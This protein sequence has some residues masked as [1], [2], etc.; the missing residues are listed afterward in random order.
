[1]MLDD[2]RVIKFRPPYILLNSA[3]MPAPGVYHLIEMT[4]DE[5]VRTIQRASY[6]QSIKS[7]IGYPDTAKHVEEITGLPV[8]VNR[9][10][11]TL[12]DSATLFIV[13]LRYRV[14]DPAQKGQFTPDSA[15]YAYFIAKYTRE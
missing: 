14:N 10:E 5:W 1:L 7:Y 4:Q 13:K 8:E 11:T 3:M 2:S 15:D 12:G 9:A 6:Q